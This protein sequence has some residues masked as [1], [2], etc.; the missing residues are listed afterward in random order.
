MEFGPHWLEPSEQD[1]QE[2]V[3][4][5]RQ[6][7]TLLGTLD[8]IFSPSSNPHDVSNHY[9]GVVGERMLRSWYQPV[10]GSVWS[11]HKVFE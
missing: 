2:F 7:S 1:I 11:Q 10:F 5:M 6:R 8:A 9:L 4:E 3:Q